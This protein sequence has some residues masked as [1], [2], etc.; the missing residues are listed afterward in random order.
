MSVFLTL[1]RWLAFGVSLI[2]WFS[3]VSHTTKLKAAFLPLVTLSF[4]TVVLFT[5]G[6]LGELPVLCWILLFTGLGLF[7]FYIVYAFFRRFSFS[8]LLSPGVLFF[9]IASALFIPILWGAHYY[10]YDNFSHWGTVLSEMLAFNSFPTAQTV[11]VFRDYMPGTA[12]FLYWFCSVVGRGE[13]IALMGQALF[14]CAALSAL[15]FRVKKVRSF[16]FFAFSVLGAAL[17]CFLVYDDGTLQIYNLLVDALMGFVALG[18]WFLREEYRDSPLRAWLFI[19]PVLTFFVLIK[20]NSLL[21][22]VFFA[23]FLLY[24]ARKKVSGKLKGWLVLLPL[25]LPL[26]WILFWKLYRQ[27]TY[28][29]PTN[30][31]AYYGL[32]HTF[33][34][35]T[36]SFY[37]EILRV[38]FEK[39]T[40]FSQIYVIVFLV[41]NLLVLGLLFLLRYK[42]RDLTRLFRT[43]LAANGLMIGYTAALMFMYGFVMAVGE[44]VYLAAFERYII[45]PLILF[46]AMLTESSVTSFLNA[47]GGK[48]MVL[49]A[50]PVWFCLL[51]FSLVSVNASQLVLRPD[52]ASSQRGQVIQVLQSAAENIP[53]N[54]KVAMCNGQR[55]RRDLYYYLMMYELK[56]R[57]CFVLDFVSPQYN[58]STDVEMLQHYDYLIIASRYYLILP[59]LAKA[60]FVVNWDKDCPIYRISP[61]TS[62]GGIISPVQFDLSE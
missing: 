29:T 14:S 9:F 52:F 7:L 53:R 24:D 1:L 56:T 30:S 22:F 6:L 8:F 12:S 5:A 32:V 55:G 16:Q 20:S 13:D 4:L 35:R 46:A 2:G 49:R 59:E 33:K 47:F 11:V 10:H 45:T 21:L 43:F 42:R 18:I 25:G 3:L 57:A 60:G 17:T 23:L 48:R 50:V 36:A 38:F 34:E 61:L 37:L 28:G 62:G 27:I 40:D 51:V 54:S 44:A 31:Y 41:L 58:I 15:F 19:A 39:I 26:L